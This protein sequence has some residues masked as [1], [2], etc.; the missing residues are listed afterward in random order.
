MAPRRM[1]LSEYMPEE[2]LIVEAMSSGITSSD[3]PRQTLA[4]NGEKECI[5]ISRR[6][7]ILILDLCNMPL[8][9]GTRRVSVTY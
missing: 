8:T 4:D 6:P 3:V 1:L 2:S 5:D 9:H 7:E